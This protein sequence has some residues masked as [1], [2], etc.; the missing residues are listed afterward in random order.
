MA[1]RDL[2]IAVVGAGASVVLDESGTTIQSARVSVGAVAPIPLFIREA[3]EYLAGKPVS[4]EVIEHAAKFST[5]AANPINDVRG[6]AN[7][8]GFFGVAQAG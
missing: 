1:D 8:C 7:D 5:E 4:D 2:R 6:T 3:G